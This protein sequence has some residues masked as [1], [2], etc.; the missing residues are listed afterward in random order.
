MD[1]TDVLQ[2]RSDGKL[3][4]DGR[5]LYFDDMLG[6]GDPNRARLRPNYP[7]VMNKTYPAKAVDEDKVEEPQEQLVAHH[8]GEQQVSQHQ[9]SQVVL[10]IGKPA[11]GGHDDA[12][13]VE[14]HYEGEEAAVCVVPE[15]EPD[16]PTGFGPLALRLRRLLPSRSGRRGLF[17]RR[18][19]CRR[20]AGLFDGGHGRLGGKD[21]P[22][23]VPVWHRERR[24]ARE[25]RDALV[26][27]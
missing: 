19:G 6:R 17:E 16:P 22:A 26:D 1:S 24:H 7:E 9:C 21:G 5:P 25:R 20:D 18:R 23:P 4:A 11:Q 8:D 12:S 15:L 2:R 27:G 14:Q 13:Q 3:Q 10:G